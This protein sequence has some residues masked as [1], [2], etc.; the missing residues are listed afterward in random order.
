MICREASF[1]EKL[2]ALFSQLDVLEIGC[3]DGSRLKAISRGFHR[4]VGIDADVRCILTS[5]RPVFPSNFQILTGRA[6]SLPLAAFTFDAVIFTLSFHHVPIEKM[7]QAIREALRV[8]KNEGCIIFLEP[9]PE[10]SF[11]EAELRF[12]C[13]DGDERKQM[14]AAFQTIKSS[15]QLL[16]VSE[17]TDTVYLEYDSF[18]D[19]SDHEYVRPES[20][21]DLK[22]FLQQNDYRLSEKRRMNVFRKP[23]I[24]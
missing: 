17:F 20:E 18:Q 14:A 7:P 3:G 24:A 23:M 12:G 5:R 9:T 16:E 11:F 15:K 21:R 6:E 13:C 22:R 1:L 10:G 8:V 4:W 19:F 2:S